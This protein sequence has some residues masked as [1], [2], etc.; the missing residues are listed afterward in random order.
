ML[1]NAWLTMFMGVGADAENHI[2][3]TG[4]VNERFR[5]PAQIGV[6]PASEYHHTKW[7]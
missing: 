2:N 7:N 1:C 6:Q 5:H 4:V 3:S